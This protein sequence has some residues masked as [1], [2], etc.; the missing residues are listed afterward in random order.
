MDGW[1]FTSHGYVRPSTLD[2]FL[3]ST[4]VVQRQKNNRRRRVPFSVRMLEWNDVSENWSTCHCWSM[5]RRVPIENEPI[6]RVSSF[7]DEDRLPPTRM[8]SWI[9]ECQSTVVESDRWRRWPQDV[10]DA[11]PSA[12]NW[13][14]TYMKHRTFPRPGHTENNRD[15]KRIPKN[16]SVL[17]Q[18]VPNRSKSQE[19]SPRRNS[20]R[21]RRSTND[22]CV[23][24]TAT[25]LQWRRFDTEVERRTLERDR[26]GRLGGKSPRE[27][28]QPSTTGTNN[29]REC[30]R[31]KWIKTID[32]NCR[33]M[34]LQ[35]ENNECQSIIRHTQQR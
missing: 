30:T 2:L 26:E 27:V 9:Y 13:R 21:N 33:P 32:H 34:N 4:P 28:R 10:V 12:N 15:V 29:D 1:W 18:D 11:D 20:H 31:L 5:Y 22:D 14:R 3:F 6:E 23:N 16:R 7:H 8:S 35:R 25:R 24:S 19:N 17:H